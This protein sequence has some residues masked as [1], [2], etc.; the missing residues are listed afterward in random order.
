MMRMLLLKVLHIQL[1]GSY[2]FKI[3]YYNK[4]KTIQLSYQ[5]G[6]FQII[7]KYFTLKVAKTVNKRKGDTNLTD[8]KNPL[9]IYKMKSV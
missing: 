2:Y 8:L 3:N 5:G 1:L 6:T 9:H 7:I 4:N